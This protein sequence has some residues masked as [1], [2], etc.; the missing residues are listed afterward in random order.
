MCIP[1]GRYTIVA[2]A[3]THI[4]TTAGLEGRDAEHTAVLVFDPHV[5]DPAA[6]GEAPT[7]LTL[8]IFNAPAA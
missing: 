2:V 3:S 4:S 1:R 8:E 7:G 5:A 6:E